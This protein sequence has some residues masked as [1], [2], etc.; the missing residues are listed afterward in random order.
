MRDPDAKI[1]PNDESLAITSAP[2]Y[3]APQMSPKTYLKA[4]SMLRNKTRDPAKKERILPAV[5]QDIK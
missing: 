4:T 3:I 5:W 1:L 2:G